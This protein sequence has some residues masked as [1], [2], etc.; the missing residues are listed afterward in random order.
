MVGMVEAKADC[1]CRMVLVEMRTVVTHFGLETWGVADTAVEERVA[2]GTEA[3]EKV[4]APGSSEVVDRP[5]VHSDADRSFDS[6]TAAAIPPAIDTSDA[7]KQNTA[8]DSA[9]G[10]AAVVVAVVGRN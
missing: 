2:V 7:E 6:S 4:A 3:E 5:A 8:P 10:T 1:H 9:A